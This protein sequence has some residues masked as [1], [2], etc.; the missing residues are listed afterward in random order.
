MASGRQILQGIA[1]YAREFGPWGI[2]HEPGHMQETLPDWLVH[3][4]GDG[5]IARVRTRQIAN[6]LGSTGIPVV[7]VLGG[8]PHA[9]IPLVQVSDEAVARLAG[10]HLADRGFRHFGFCGVHGPHWARLRRDAFVE[11]VCAR[12]HHCDVYQL[13]RRE[14]PEW[15]AETERERL[16]QWIARLAKPA[17][18]MACNDTA[19]QRV[20]DACR[21]AGVDVPESVAVLGVDNDESLCEMSDPRLSSIIPVHDLVGYQAAQTLDAMMQGKRPD[22]QES[23]LEPTEVVTRR[24]TDILAIEDTELAAAVRFIHD[25]ACQGIGVDDVVRS[26]GVSYST[27]KRRFREILGRSVHDEILR[28]RLDRVQELLAGT[29]LSVAAIARKTGFEHQEYLGAVFKA[30]LHTTPNAFRHDH[31][32]DA[33]GR[34]GR[35]ANPGAPGSPRG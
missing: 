2:Y 4:R 24:S 13:P 14:T 21:R 10:T 6:S 20:L 7:D 19:G 12:G 18:I 15:Y 35:P 28:I 8:F 3:W 9:K 1:R 23:L 25:H 29:E 22:W 32:S 34:S 17:G 33:I 30:H 31:R 26:V 5:I 11:F 16:A 27:L